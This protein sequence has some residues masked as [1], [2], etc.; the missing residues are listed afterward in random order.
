MPIMPIYWYTFVTQES[1]A[2]RDS[3]SIN[4]LNQ[5]DLSKVR[6]VEA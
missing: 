4:L 6:M 2:V 1:A 5:F 3:F